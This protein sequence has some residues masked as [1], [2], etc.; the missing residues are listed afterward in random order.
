MPQCID[1]KQCKENEDILSAYEHVCAED[2]E[3]IDSERDICDPATGE[4]CGAFVA[5]E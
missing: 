5:E 1:C 4:P 3:E 2:G